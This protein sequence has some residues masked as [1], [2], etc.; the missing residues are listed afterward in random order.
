MRCACLSCRPNPMPGIPRQAFVSLGSIHAPSSLLNFGEFMT[1]PSACAWSSASARLRT[2]SV[3]VWSFT[4]LSLA[5]ASSS[6]PIFFGIGVWGSYSARVTFR[7]HI[8]M[9]RFLS[10]LATVRR[11][12]LVYLMVERWMYRC[13]AD[14]FPRGCMSFVSTV[15]AAGCAVYPRYSAAI[16]IFSMAHPIL[17]AA[18]RPRTSEAGR[19]AAWSAYTSISFFSGVSAN[20]HGCELCVFGASVPSV[21]RYMSFSCAER[22]WNCFGVSWGVSHA[23]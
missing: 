6:R 12:F 2:G 16:T 10:A 3:M 21:E 13:A 1:N 4:L 9:K 7:V 8:L 20:L 5:A 18:C 23:A 22:S 14:F 19:I 15:C 11:V 17:I